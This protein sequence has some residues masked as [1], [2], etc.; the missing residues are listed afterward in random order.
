MDRRYAEAS[1]GRQMVT[2]AT[3]RGAAKA[4]GRSPGPESNPGSMQAATMSPH[5][6]YKCNASGRP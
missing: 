5:K 4:E 3:H 6:D 2:P 1:D